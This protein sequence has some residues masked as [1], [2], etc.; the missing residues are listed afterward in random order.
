[1]IRP[2]NQAMVFLVEAMGPKA[3]MV[4]AEAALRSERTETTETGHFF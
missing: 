4:G 1:M 2:T 3:S